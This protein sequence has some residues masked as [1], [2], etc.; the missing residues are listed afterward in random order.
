[1]YPTHCHHG[2]FKSKTRCAFENSLSLKNHPEKLDLRLILLFCNFKKFHP[3][4]K[5][6]PDYPQTY[7]FT[8]PLL[9]R[10]F[11]KFLFQFCSLPLYFQLI[12]SGF[13]HQ[14]NP[15]DSFLCPPTHNFCFRIV[16]VSH[17]KTWSLLLVFLQPKVHQL[18]SSWQALERYDPLSGIVGIKIERWMIKKIIIKLD[19]FEEHTQ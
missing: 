1:M 6:F 18:N 3:I 2:L 16:W 9:D 10:L 17:A 15:S 5:S 8:H 7:R 12:K 4:S 19:K 13:N 14:S 11:I